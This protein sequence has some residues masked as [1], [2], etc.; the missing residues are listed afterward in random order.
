LVELLDYEKNDIQALAMTFNVL[1]SGLLSASAEVV[2]MTG[3]T[4]NKV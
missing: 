3:R 2:N 4:L 1:K